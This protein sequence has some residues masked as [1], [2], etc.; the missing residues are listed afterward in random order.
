MPY[1]KPYSNPADAYSDF[2]AFA[3]QARTK[4]EAHP[5]WK[6]W[7]LSPEI[8][9]AS[10]IRGAGKWRH[11]WLQL[12][13]NLADSFDG[14]IGALRRLKQ[15]E[16]LRIGLLDFS[17]Y[18]TVEETMRQVS[19]L[20]DFCLQVV[21]ESSQK[22]L[23]SRW[24]KPQ[25][26]FAILGM[27]KLGGQ[28]LN[29]SSDI[30]V[31]FIYGEEGQLTPQLGYHEYFAR[32]CQK[33]IGAFSTQTGDGNLFRI[34]LRL[35]PE[36]DAGS[37][38][39]SLEACENYY[40]AYGETWER[41]AL[42]KARL[43]AGDRGLGYDFE[44]MRTAFCYP[45][46]LSS[47]VIEEIAAIKQ[48]IER[49]VVKVENLDLHVKLGTGGIREIE[50][51]IQT[52]QVLHGARLPYLQ[53]RSTLPALAA[54]A[55][56]GI[57][58]SS[59]TKILHDAYLWW[60]TVEHRLQMV[61][62]L[63]THSLPRD[64]IRRAQ[65]ADTLGLELPEFERLILDHR[66]AVREIFDEIISSHKSE[67]VPA[68][69]FATDF[70][71]QP[72]HAQKDVE[73]LAPENKSDL[74]VS[75]RTRNAYHRFCRVL[76]EKLRQ[77]VDPDLSLTRLVR[78]ADAYGSH[79]LLYESLANNPKALELLLRIF[80]QSR[81]YSELLMVRPE[82]FEEAARS[83][84]LDYRK[85]TEE[86]IV[87]LNALTGDPALEARRYRRA[88]LLRI[89][90]R[91]ILVLDQLPAI[92]REYSALARACLDYAVR[93]ARPRSPMAVIGV[94]KLGGAELSYGSDLDC[95]LVGDDVEAAQFISKFMTDM[96]P[97]GILFPLDFRLRPNG[98]GPIAMPLETYVDY[99]AN[100]AQLWEIQAFIRAR[101][102]AGDKAL[103]EAFFAAIDPIW[104]ERGKSENFAAEVAHMRYRIE[105]ERV[106]A[107]HKDLEFKT[108][109]GGMI[110][111]EFGL[112]TYLISKGE[113]EPSTWKGL[114]ILGR[115]N[116]SLATSWR[117]DYLFLRYIESILRSDQNSSVSAIPK[118]AKEQARLARRMG[119]ATLE[120]F[121]RAY[122][123][124]RSRI[125][126]GYAQLM[127]PEP[128]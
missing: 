87:Q 28:E 43:S 16:Y 42:L 50:F 111:V 94:G 61:A 27:G 121:K 118:E 93:Q 54:A 124:T 101:Y 112:Q 31:I 75:Q 65:I 77:C 72:E 37:L 125:R 85:T 21:L 33:I 20:A 63:Q 4:I 36:G 80:D 29:Y 108:G 24:G 13:G 40:A 78:F 103:A 30:D 91:D 122:D 41:M 62:D 102:V 119:F 7:L 57:L 97:T 2:I 34:D 90:L 76:E 71:E 8:I 15:R 47:D 25:T 86:Y 18:A 99:Y 56:L 38:A 10:M 79:G 107:A 127:P 14:A 52:L 51:I 35:R 117:R 46:S 95:L 19:D 100:H 115:E 126:D 1:A 114:D 83:G 64:P 6:D 3:S 60:R 70:F 110:D 120:E 128:H 105:T 88:E 44:Q 67:T 26:P 11:D 12:A 49:E 98:K 116:P 66:H 9:D 53:H 106:D 55:T 69:S 109:V 123:L 92:Q 39:S 17:G 59:K 74:H 104:K 32:L 73:S 81:F 22:A 45:R 89:F 84:T 113:R 96:M 82:L 23:E 48:R 68:V 5:E 58:P